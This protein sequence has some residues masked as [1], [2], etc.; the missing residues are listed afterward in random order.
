MAAGGSSWRLISLHDASRIFQKDGSGPWYI[1]R[2]YIVTITRKVK[3]SDVDVTPD[4]VGYSSA[5]ISFSISGRTL[6]RTRIGGQKYTC[7]EDRYETLDEASNYVNR[8]QVW[9]WLEAEDQAKEI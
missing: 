9:E 3:S 5:S 8:T 1:Q 2:H 7:R 4:V 6:S